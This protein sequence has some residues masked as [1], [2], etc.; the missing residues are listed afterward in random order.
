MSRPSNWTH[1]GTES[2]AMQPISL[3]HPTARLHL[4][5]ERPGVLRA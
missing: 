1:D 4:G 5:R 2:D 3:R